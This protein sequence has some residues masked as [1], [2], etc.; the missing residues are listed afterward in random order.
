MPAST[1]DAL[2]FGSDVFTRA[3]SSSDLKPLASRYVNTPQGLAR[4]LRE[5]PT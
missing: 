1:N 5:V 2:Y 3:S 4:A